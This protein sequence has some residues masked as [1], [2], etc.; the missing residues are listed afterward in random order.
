MFEFQCVSR[1]DSGVRCGRSRQGS[2]AFILIDACEWEPFG[3]LSERLDAAIRFGACAFGCR[4][5]AVF[6][7]RV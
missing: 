3:R 4:V 1:C 2:A 6:Q 7:R 5:R